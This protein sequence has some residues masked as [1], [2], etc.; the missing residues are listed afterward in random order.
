M[1]AV[2]LWIGRERLFAESV[3]EGRPDCVLAVTS[4]SGSRPV[5]VSFSSGCSLSVSV[6]R[7]R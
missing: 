3:C 4:G 7:L 5:E 2:R 1:P 6:V